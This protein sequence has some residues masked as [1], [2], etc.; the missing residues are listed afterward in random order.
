M[1]D[2]ISRGEDRRPPSR[3]RRTAAALAVV[4]VAAL[5]VVEHLPHSA[6]PARHHGAGRRS[7]P[8]TNTPND[9]A[10]NIPSGITG[11]TG[12]LPAQTR[13]PRTGTRPA[14]FLPANGKIE[15]IGGL[16]PAPAGY[17]F[18]R[19]DS[20][21]AIQP[22]ANAQSSCVGCPG[23]SL[24]VYY[25]AGQAKAATRVGAATMVAPGTGG[26]WWLTSYPADNRLGSKSGTARQYSSAGVPEGPAVR[27]PAGFAIARGTTAGV[28]L[29]SITERTPAGFYWLWDP[30]TGKIV[31]S[32]WGVVAASA[33][34]VAVV[35]NC[36]STCVVEVVNPASGQRTSLKLDGQGRVTAASFSSDGRYL[37]FAVIFDDGLVNGSA[38][39]LEVASL[40]TGHLTVVPHAGVTSDA[41]AGFGWPGNGDRLV[42]ELVFNT[43]TQVAFWKPGIRTPAVAIIGPAQD[44][45]DLVVG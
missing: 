26:G 3:W 14:W 43:S 39:V 45:G 16:P 41:L 25:L 23:T 10:V 42:A 19:L 12:K 35:R 18:T 11:A 6:A 31:R 38:T 7:P 9:P 36:G 5:V 40:K 24:P 32:F 8:L 22:Q 21:W 37:A 13:L 4:A 30:A 28:L 33:T 20:G 34:G 1:E 15:A 17:T 44:P 29:F 27:L 2:I